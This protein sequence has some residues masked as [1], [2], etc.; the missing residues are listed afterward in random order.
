MDPVAVIDTETTGLP[1]Y[2]PQYIVEIG[3]ALLDLENG[4]IYKVMDEIVKEK[5]FDEKMKNAWVFENSDLTYEQVDNGRPLEDVS[6]TIQNVLDSFPVTAYNSEFDLNFVRNSGFEI[7]KEYPCIMKCATGLYKIKVPWGDK[8]AS[9][10][11][12]W[13]YLFDDEYV[14]SHRAY[15]DAVH[16]AKILKRLYDLGVWRKIDV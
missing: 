11:E 1:K 6:A 16:A 12:A 13:F 14:E 10:E 9:L 3:I 8:W 15:D 4:E 5:G 7:T 2:P